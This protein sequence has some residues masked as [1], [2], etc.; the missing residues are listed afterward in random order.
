MPVFQSYVQPAFSEFF[1]LKME[2]VSCPDPFLPIY[3]ST[4]LLIYWSTW[5]DLHKNITNNSHIYY[6]ACNLT[7][8]TLL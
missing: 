4:D 2:T 5:S 1:T 6:L 7:H 8:M 3:W